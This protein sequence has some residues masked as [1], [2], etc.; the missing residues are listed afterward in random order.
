MVENFLWMSKAAAIYFE[1]LGTCSLTYLS[2]H[3]TKVAKQHAFLVINNDILLDVLPQRRHFH[4]P[5]LVHSVHVCL[6][7]PSQTLPPTDRCNL[8]W[9]C[10]PYCHTNVTENINKKTAGVMKK[11]LTKSFVTACVGCI[12]YS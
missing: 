1:R 3:F 7:Q 8:W 6:L 9:L 11:T 12:L 10:H 4:R 2:M 5:F